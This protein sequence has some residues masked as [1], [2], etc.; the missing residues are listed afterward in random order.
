MV[1]K[2]C[3]DV[4]FTW[5]GEPVGKEVDLNGI[6][7]YVAMPAKET[8]KAVILASDVFGYDKKNPRLYADRLAEAGFLAVLP[9]LIKG[10]PMTNFAEKDAWLARHPFD[11]VESMLT[12]VLEAVA[13]DHGATSFGVVGFCWGGHFAAK[14][15]ATDNVKA[16]VINHGSMLKQEHIDALKQPALFNCNENDPQIPDEFRARIWETLKAKDNGSAVNLFLGKG[17]THGFSLRG[18]DKDPVVSQAA[19]AAFVAGADFF[20]HYL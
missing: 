7:A 6:K 5:D 10:D 19:K 15:A 20:S 1:C 11:E 3:V 4:G 14:L 9:D 8:N 13:K 16:V 2:E 17:V 18:D 12:S